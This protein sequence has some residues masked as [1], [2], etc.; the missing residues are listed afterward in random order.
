MRKDLIGLVLILFSAIL[1]NY[2]LFIGNIPF[3]FDNLAF[4]HPLFSL[5]KHS[6]SILWDPY[7]FSGFPTFAEPQF[8]MFYPLRWLFNLVNVFTAM[9]IFYII[10]YVLGL[11][12]MYLFLRS[13]PLGRTA[14]TGGTFCYIH[15][16]YFQAKML[17]SGTLF[18]S[19]AWIPLFM[20][21][22]IRAITGNMHILTDSEQTPNNKTVASYRSP[23]LRNAIYAGLVL[24][25][26]AVIGSPHHM[27]YP[28]LAMVISVLFSIGSTKYRETNTKF[29]K[30]YSILYPFFLITITVLIG[31]GIGAIQLIP[32]NEL[33]TRSIRAN[34][35]FSQVV[36]TPLK[37]QWILASF[38]GGTQT[39][40]FLDASAY[41]G[42][43]GLMLIFFAFTKRNIDTRYLW[44][45]LTTAIL[46]I[47]I[48]RGQYA[49]FYHIFYHLPFLKS[50]SFPC[51]SLVL[52]A[53][54][55][56]V[57]TAY[58][59]ETV[60][61]VQ[62]RYP[63]S[64]I[65]NFQLLTS[66][67]LLLISIIVLVYFY[68]RFGT[69]LIQTLLNTKWADPLLYRWAN[70]C[71]FTLLTSFTVILF[72]KNHIG[73]RTFQILILIILFADLYQFTPRI[74]KRFINA[75]EY[76]SPPAAVQ[77]LQQQ[78]KAPVRII[79]FHSSRLYA[80]DQN[81]NRFKEYL[82]PKLA[83]LYRLQDA[84]GYDPLML[85]KYVTVMQR[86]AGRSP[87]EDP[88]R[89]ATVATCTPRFLNLLNIG[90]IVGE[91]NEFSVLRK[92]IVLA[93]GI[94]TTLSVSVDTPC[95]E[96]GLISLLDRHL[97]T[98]QGTQI[99]TITITDSKGVN[100]ILP[101]RAG[102]ETADW[103]I[104][105]TPAAHRMP[106]PAMTWIGN[107]AG[108]EYT[109]HNFYTRLKFTK[110]II[111]KTIT[112]SHLRIPG[113]IVVQHITLIKQNDENQF[114]KL[115]DF[116]DVRIYQ[117]KTVYPRAF[118][119][120]K[121]EVIPDEAK[122]LEKIAAPTADLR[123]T[124][125]LQEPI[126]VRLNSH[127]LTLKPDTVTITRFSPNRIELE[128]ESDHNSFLVLSEID[129][130]GWQATVDGKP[131]KI[132]TTNY[133][134]R[135]LYLES[136]KHRIVLTFRPKSL[137]FGAILSLTTLVIS[138]LGIKLTAKT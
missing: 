76:L 37:S 130:P 137:F 102:I 20:L 46:A 65:R 126:P 117:N 3:D 31:V 35:T 131:T 73:L 123:Y 42:V 66:Y 54:A 45:W 40:E 67:F 5:A 58:G 125:Y 64:G 103:R 122:L 113:I 121:I 120:H 22:A 25:I 27:F 91:V 17:M 28:V 83:E 68:F 52:L 118:L 57:L 136:G 44:F 14:A 124:A 77:F 23:H 63:K 4:Y 72:W 69:L 96:L 87:T 51:R 43:A 19:M 134:L 13:L 109:L 55:G 34:L 48:A 12:F 81:D 80:I 95:L 84:H 132:Y 61:Q 82:A 99:G 112:I 89:M 32:G 33:F 97:K 127:Q 108:K 24:G 74:Q 93:S 114:T 110:P 105:T 29:P 38:L 15:G 8:A 86:L 107:L 11:V 106:Q 98:P 60:M 101:I 100:E 135:G 75:K 128:S 10:H 90:Y 59:I 1:I 2:Q 26:I 9:P 71:L 88:Q 56:A 16:S 7:Q 62:I 18:F 78:I 85:Q 111:P 119:V 70:L 50:L 49:P 116:G 39:P 94:E 53:L 133:I 47:L 92:Q 21:F 115:A 104:E 6:P 41:F 129:Y 138:L 36:E 30:W 79:G